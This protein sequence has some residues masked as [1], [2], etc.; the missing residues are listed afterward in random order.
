[1]NAFSSGQTEMWSASMQKIMEKPLFGDEIGPFF[2][3]TG[4]RL[5][6]YHSHSFQIE[7]LL[8]LGL[9]VAGELIALVF[10]FY[11]NLT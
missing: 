6:T 5:N 3:A 9:I 2:L 8:N 7:A 11:W 10:G 1:M 4:Y